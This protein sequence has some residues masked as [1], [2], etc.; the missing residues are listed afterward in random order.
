MNLQ[1]RWRFP[2]PPLHRSLVI[3]LLLF[4]MAAS[5]FA[6]F[7]VLSDADRCHLGQLSYCPKETPT[8]PEQTDDGQTDKTTTTTTT[9][10]TNN[11]S[12]GEAVFSVVSIERVKMSTCENLPGPVTVTGYT[13]DTQCQIVPAAGVGN[14]ELTRRGILI[15]VDIWGW[16][17]AELEVCFSDS[18]ALAFLDAAYSPRRLLEMAAE[19]RDDMTCGTIG[20]AGTVV[21]FM[22]DEPSAPAAP[23]EEPA[24]ATDE[25]IPLDDCQIKLVETLF[26][27]DAP[28]GEIIGL[29]W[30]NSEVPAFEI[31]GHWYKIEFEGQT[32][33]ISRYHRKVL[34]GGCG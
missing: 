23:P 25:T 15:A 30:L 1:S 6:Q 19:T 26:L 8:E 14:A 9:T 24:P 20:S 7:D 2:F 34:R 13:I 5:T 4:M 3:A 11:N 21:L 10:T 16:V 33:Y 18:G 12:G 22:S 27:R 28:L 29:V 32:G 17:S 31:A